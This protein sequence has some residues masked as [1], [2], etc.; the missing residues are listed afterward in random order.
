MSIE[1][2][3]KHSGVRDAA[4]SFK[5]DDEVPNKRLPIVRGVDGNIFVVFDEL[6]A[7]DVTPRNNIDGV[8]FA[9]IVVVDLLLMA[10]NFPARD[11]GGVSA[12]AVFSKSSLFKLRRSRKSHADVCLVNFG[13]GIDNDDFFVVLL[14]M[15]ARFGDADTVGV[16]S[17]F[18][19]D[20]PI[21]LEYFTFGVFLSDIF[22]WNFHT[23]SYNNG[24]ICANFW[25]KTIVD[26]SY[27]HTLTR[28]Q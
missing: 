8:W 24:Y 11:S 22:L 10:E 4:A 19:L 2:F 7:V 6:D 5:L 3:E 14:L 21:D 27:A 20:A 15:V 16:D 9:L 23:I 25:Q 28:K 12:N 17:N 18:P 26:R 1:T 13:F